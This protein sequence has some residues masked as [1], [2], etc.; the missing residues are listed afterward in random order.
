[1]CQRQRSMPDLGQ[2][3]RRLHFLLFRVH[4]HQWNLRCNPAM[5]M[6]KSL[7]SYIGQLLKLTEHFGKLRISLFFLTKYGSIN[8]IV[9]IECLNII[10]RCL[11]I[12]PTSSTS[13]STCKL[14]SIQFWLRKEHP[15]QSYPQIGRPGG[16][17]DHL[18]FHRELGRN[19][20]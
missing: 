18:R 16:L 7:V 6:N 3:N 5:I 1:M 9:G 17:P 14:C 11:L 12:C 15:L 8:K 20:C 2:H 10:N 4:K 19:P 13:R